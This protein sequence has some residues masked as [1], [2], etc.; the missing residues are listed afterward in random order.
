MEFRVKVDIPEMPFKIDRKTPLLSLG[1]CFSQRIGIRLEKLLFQIEV[2]PFG[3]VY[4][5]LSI[6]NALTE[7][8]EKKTYSSPDLCKN[9]ELFYS[10]SH[11]TL[12]SGTNENDVL[13]HINSRINAANSMLRD[14]PLVMITLGTA[15][16][17]RNIEMDKVVANCHKLPGALFERELLSVETVV[18]AL[19][20][21][22]DS[23]KGVAPDAKI[24]FTVSPV[25]HLRDGLVNDQLG[26]SILFVA[27]S[28][29]RKVH[30][31][32]LYFPAYE[33]L[34]HELR[35]YR[36]YAEDMAHPTDQAAEYI[37]Q[38]FEEALIQPSEHDISKKIRSIQQAM[39]HR[40]QRANT[41]EFR[42]F[43]QDQRNRVTELLQQ[44]PELDL[45]EQASYFEAIL[46]GDD[47]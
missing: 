30:A 17:F 41:V 10:F 19:S 35:D 12:F 43:A 31:E 2:D 25:R 28:E 26:K 27:L 15:W 21:A 40:I 45:T 42:K 3:V 46:S 20:R 1:S 18:S 47:Q 13:D 8:A 9:K 36:Y 6:S 22:L 16:A 11:S 32:V 24:L 33:L 7:I 44:R 5:P 38:R 4:D 29:L 39:Q 14:A 34:V 37:W 23:L